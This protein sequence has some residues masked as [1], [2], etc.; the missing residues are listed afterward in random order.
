M[1]FDATDASIDIL[2]LVA[3]YRDSLK[4]SDNILV[5]GIIVYYKYIE[6]SYKRLKV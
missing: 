2:E 6:Y 4:S 3:Y 1:L 5:V